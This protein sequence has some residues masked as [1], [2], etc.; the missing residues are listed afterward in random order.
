MAERDLVARATAQHGLISRSQALGAGLSRQAI[1]RRLETGR[2]TLLRPGVY[3]VGAPPSTWHQQVLSAC[4]AGGPDVVVSHRSAARLWGLVDA[5]GRTEVTVAGDRRVRLPG[6]RVHQSILLPE[7]D[8]VVR[9]QVPVTSLSRTLADVASHQ[10]PRTVGQWVDQAM[11]QEALDLRDLRC[12]LAR[13]AGPGRRDLRPI[14]A[15]LDL[16]APGWDPGDSALEARA[17]HALHHGGL[18]APV[19]QHPVR[20][21]NGAVAEL[22][23]AYLPEKVAIELDGWAEHGK[24]GAFERDRARRN[25]LTLLG[26]EVYQFTWAMPDLVLVRVVSEAL[27]RRRLWLAS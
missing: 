27:A 12:C 4:L 20:R 2:W 1:G 11:R 13:L 22:D 8:R 3:A 17:L 15:A 26:W 9:E 14:R 10:D 24:R 18:P 21:P 25:D 5:D 7:L 19:Q 6:V 23:L 16:R